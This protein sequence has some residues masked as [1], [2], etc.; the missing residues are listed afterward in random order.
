[1]AIFTDSSG[2]VGK[3]TLIS[4][5]TYSRFNEINAVLI[6]NNIAF[7]SAMLPLEYIHLYKMDDPNNFLYGFEFDNN[8]DAV[9]FRLSYDPH[10]VSSLN[11]VLL[12]KIYSMI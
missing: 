12:S 5:L 10:A 1:M 3:Y 2:E 6:S 8:A 9:M 7:K 11:T 4:E